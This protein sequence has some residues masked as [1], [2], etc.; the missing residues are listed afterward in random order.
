MS[1]KIHLS[2]EK[3]DAVPQQLDF[4]R[5]MMGVLPFSRCILLCGDA[6]VGQDII[7]ELRNHYR[8]TEVNR[9]L[10]VRG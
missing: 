9:L 1:L 7:E 3:P 4:R 10:A 2:P 5:I 6:S 8:S